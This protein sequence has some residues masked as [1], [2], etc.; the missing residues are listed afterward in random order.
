LAPDPAARRVTVADIAAAAG[1]SRATV[2]KVLNGRSDVAAD[3]RALVE[4]ILAERS[5]VPTKR[6]KVAAPSAGGL[7]EMLFNDAATPWAVEMIR[8][9]E[10]AAR[11]ARVGVVVSTLGGGP[12]SGHQWVEDVA[13]RRSRGL[14]LALSQLSAADQKLITK[15]GVPAILVDPV[16]DFDSHFPSIGADNWGG[17]MLATRHLVELGHRRIATVTGPMRFLCSQ[18]R[19][20]GYR[21]ALERAGLPVDDRLIAPGDFHYQSALSSALGLLD[22]PEP[23]TAIFAANDE[24]ALAVYAAVQQRGLRIPADLSVV[25][26]DDV[27]MSQWITPPLTTVRQPITELAALATRTLLG[28]GEAGQ[29]GADLPGRVELATTLVVRASTA[30]PRHH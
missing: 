6:T 19:V 22:L 4:G 27:P 18:A 11:A 5:Y 1:V 28:R 7:V 16:G 25:G 13:S 15:L 10:Q 21:A 2:S 29:P 8:G 14:I 3:T 12:D 26:F 30:P 24:Q 17:G 23:P 20:A 9:A